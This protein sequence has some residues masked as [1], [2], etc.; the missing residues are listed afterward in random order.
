MTEKRRKKGRTDVKTKT[1][2]RVFQ[3]TRTN[4]FTAFPKSHS[5]RHVGLGY[6]PPIHFLNSKNVKTNHRVNYA[7]VNVYDDM[8]YF[9]GDYMHGD[10]HNSCDG[11]APNGPYPQRKKKRNSSRSSSPKLT[12]SSKLKEKSEKKNRRK[13]TVVLTPRNQFGNRSLN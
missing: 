13:I 2:Q 7:F 5:P 9:F 3:K 11:Y 12:K 8:L 1:P 10:V 6:E 4:S